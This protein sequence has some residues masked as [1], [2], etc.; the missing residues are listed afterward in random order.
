MGKT[1][2]FRVYEILSLVVLFKSKIAS[3]LQKQ[4]KSETYCEIFGKCRKVEKQSPTKFTEE[5]IDDQME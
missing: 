1:D 4:F 2:N 3:K 5:I